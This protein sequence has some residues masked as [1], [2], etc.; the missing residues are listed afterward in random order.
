MYTDIITTQMKRS[1]IL[2]NSDIVRT[3]CPRILTIPITP[4]PDQDKAK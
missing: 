3:S 4:S 1:K 2:V